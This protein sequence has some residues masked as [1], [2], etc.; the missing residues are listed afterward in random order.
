MNKNG[1]LELFITSTGSIFASIGQLKDII[2]TQ[3]GNS[4]GR[5]V[6]SVHPHAGGELSSIFIGYQREFV[7]GI[8]AFF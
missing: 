2:P 1:I 3:V 8:F 4:L 5:F 7:P 6:L